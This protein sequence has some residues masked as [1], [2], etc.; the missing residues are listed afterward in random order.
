MTGP[1]RLAAPDFVYGNT[2]LRARRGE[3]PEPAAG[4][5]PQA[6]STL[7]RSRLRGMHGLYSGAAA[8][9]VGAVLAGFDVADVVTLLRGAIGRQP[10]QVVLPAVLAVHRVTEAAA[11]DVAAAGEA[12][13][14]VQRLREYKLPDPDTARELPGIWERYELHRDSAELERELAQTALGHRLATLDAYGAAA[15]PVRAALLRERHDLARLGELRGTSEGFEATRLEAEWLEARQSAA[16]LGWVTGDPLGSGVPL[17][18]VHQA[19]ATARRLRRDAI[20]PA[21]AGAGD[22]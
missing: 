2:R 8:D 6:A 22:A 4:T 16:M 17:A 7:L 10:A 18:A 13:A 14:A 19:Q 20:D 12:A 5:D 3:R 11:R 15:E 21:Q 1:R 9:I